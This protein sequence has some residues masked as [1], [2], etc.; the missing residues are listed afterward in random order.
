MGYSPEAQTLRQPRIV[1]LPRS[2]DRIS[3]L[4]LDRAKVFQDETGVAATLD[5]G[6]T[7][8][9]PAGSLAVLMLGQGC[10]IT[11]PA[12]A[13]LHRAG[14]NIMLSGADGTT[15]ITTA[16]PLTGRAKWAE[17][18]ARMWT[19]PNGRADAA[20]ILYSH[21]FPDLD[22]PA[23]ATIQRMR[24]LEGHQVKLLYKQHAARTKHRNWRRDT[25][26]EDQPN[27]LLN[28]ANAILYASATAAVTALGLNPAL[29]IIHQGAVG[30]LLFDLAD[31]HKA[32]ASIPLAFDCSR[33]DDPAFHLRRRMR[34]YLHRNRVLAQHLRVL[35]E[36]LTPHLDATD[37]VL[38]D[39][40]GVV[41]GHTNHAPDADPID[42]RP[43]P[44]DMEQLR[45][46][47]EDY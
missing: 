8:R 37:D 24:G 44:P 16:R 42:T 29:G 7:V 18:Q 38:L 10:S 40:H 41:A 26:G 43:P 28:L 17:A 34:A 4:H 33:D 30:A 14:C 31:I 35:D 45:Q 22:W 47:V 1:D 20:R 36:I 13:T 2:G 25:N 23:T 11:T 46:A 15:A 19:A 39:E 5:T 27:R 32:T 9:I 12:Q 3:H 21:Q 6:D